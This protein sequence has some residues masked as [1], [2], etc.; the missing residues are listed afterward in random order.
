M[1]EIIVLII[2]YCVFYIFDV[3]LGVYFTHLL[4]TI[5]HTLFVCERCSAI[6]RSSRPV[7]VTT[8]YL[9]YPV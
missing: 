9:Y 8:C 3:F 5:V 2:F 4:Y 6:C 1:W 7:L